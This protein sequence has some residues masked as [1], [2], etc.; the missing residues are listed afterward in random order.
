MLILP[1]YEGK[2]VVKEYTAEEYNVKFGTAEDIIALLDTEK[3]VKGT[4]EEMVSGVARTIPKLTDMLK[5]LIKDIFPGI[6]D[7]E[8]RSCDLAD[9]AVVIVDVFETTIIK[10]MEGSGSGKK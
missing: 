9:I 10:I 4:R 6:T 8:I 7:E 1:I 3:I 5:H 2:E